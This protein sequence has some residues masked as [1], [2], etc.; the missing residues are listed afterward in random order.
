MLTGGDT[1]MKDHAGQ[2]IGF[3]GISHDITDLKK[4][5]DALRESEAKYRSILEGI[6]EGYYETDQRGISRLQFL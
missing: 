5:W 4:A 1:L 6:E 3:R 2:P